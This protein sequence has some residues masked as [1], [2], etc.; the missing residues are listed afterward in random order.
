MS[1]A[2]HGSRRFAAALQIP[3]HQ[4]FFKC[5]PLDLILR[6]RRNDAVSKDGG[7]WGTPLPLSPVILDFILDWFAPLGQN[8]PQLKVV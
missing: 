1:Q 8:P 2:A 4:A 7:G 6:R 5:H 3:H